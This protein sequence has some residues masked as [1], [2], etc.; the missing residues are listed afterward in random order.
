MFHALSG[1][2]PILFSKRYMS[3]NISSPPVLSNAE[4]MSRRVAAVPRGVGNACAVFPDRAANAEI[5]D[6]EGRR[7][8]DFASGI[9]VLNV[10][11]VHEKV[12]AAVAAQL[13]KYWHPAFQVMPFEPYV[14]L[15]ERLNMLAPGDGAHK[16]LF[17][18][19]GA[20]AVENA[21][22]IA[23]SY[24]KR[25]GVITF[26]GGFHGRTLLTLAMTGK[27]APY[28]IGFGPMPGEVF[29]V[30]YPTVYHGISTEDSLHALDFLFKSDLD[31]SQV[32]AIV[33]EP[34]LGEGGFYVA[35]PEFLQQLRELCDIHGIVLV[36]DEIQAG[37]ARTGKMFGIEHSGVVPD[38]ITVA[39]SL[40]GGLPLSGVIGKAE[41][42]DAPGPG[43]LGGTYGGNPVACAAALAVLDVIEEE[44][45]MDRARAMGEVLRARFTALA[46]TGE[47][48]C[49]GDIRG[50]GAMT[51]VELV[52]DRASRTPA[53]EL[54]RAVTQH[55][56]QNGLVLL[57]CGIYGNT[58]RVL[59]PLT[60]PDD[61]L[62]EGLDIFET[63]LRQALKTL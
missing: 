2:F 35:P 33:I 10:G 30:P 38:L 58:L 22:K 56:L 17:L 50:L 34:V 25:P 19:S 41:I 42:M 49:I 54:T 24:T 5:W 29:H 48:E 44:N 52:K 32:A 61:V 14:E 4:L 18:S 15:A 21:V 39:K 3:S 11:H 28:K 1:L 62:A 20:E 51:A 57:S 40:A 16:T 37:F 60:I 55:A 31:P 45:L 8:I 43:G 63:S 13:D 47:F 36:A 23:R 53:P 59:A 9:A 27:V 46:K 6:V 26:T 12:K 7:H